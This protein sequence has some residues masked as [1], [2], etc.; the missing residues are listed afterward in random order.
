MKL[1]FAAVLGDRGA[2][3]AVSASR[4]AELADPVRR[5]LRPGRARLSG[6]GPS[7]RSMAKLAFTGAGVLLFGGRAGAC[8]GE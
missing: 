7:A 8:T 5:R 4:R 3:A 6:E 2:L 1:V